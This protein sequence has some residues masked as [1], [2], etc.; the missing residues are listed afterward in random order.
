[1]EKSLL[2][3]PSPHPAAEGR[4]GGQGSEEVPAQALAACSPAGAAALQERREM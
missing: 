2:P 1:M 4:Q 3:P